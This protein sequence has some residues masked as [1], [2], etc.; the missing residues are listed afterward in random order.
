MDPQLVDRVLDLAI[1]IQQIPAPTFDEKKRGE[2]IYGRFLQENLL[3]VE[4]DEIGNVLGRLPGRGNTPPIVISAHLDTVF[5]SGI[6]LLCER[7]DEKIIG[8]GIGDNA[9]GLAGL[10][11]IV[12]ELNQQQVNLN[13]DLWL[14]ANVGEEGLGDLRGMREVVNRFSDQIQAY[15]VLEGMALGQVYHRGLGVRRFRIK[16]NTSGGHSWVDY[17]KPSAVHELAQI[18][19]RLLEIRIPENPRTSLNVGV[20]SGGISVNTIAAEATLDMDLRS[21][22]IISLEELV[23][24]VQDIVQE[25]QSPEVQVNIELIGQRPVGEISKNHPL[26]AL[27]VQGLEMVGVQPRLNIGSTDANI[28]LSLGYPA[29]CLGLTTGNGAHTVHEYINLPPLELGLKQL[30]FVI[31]GLD[32]L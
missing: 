7:L 17:G 6:V 8:P 12:W 32:R 9:V 21:E 11:G 25:S 27:A 4:I 31:K 13:S 30:L 23:K 3:D 14:V 22:D 2:F 16:T 1:E 5:P 18:I 28:P 19:S 29:I 26:V 15:I 20:I 24:S 10:F